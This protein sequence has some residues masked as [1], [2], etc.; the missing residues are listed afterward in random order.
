MTRA[1]L[2]RIVVLCT[3]ALAADAA[4]TEAQISERVAD[5]AL[6]EAA[7]AA[8][9]GP[10]GRGMAANL[11]GFDTPLPDFTDCSFV[12]VEPDADWMAVAHDGGPVRA[13]D[14]MMPAFGE[15]MT[16]AELQQTLDY[17]RGFCTNTAWPR[18]ELNFP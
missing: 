9:H 12:T 11:I 13:F 7:C 6:Y 15:A 16:D 4:K 10:D 8:C 14:R 1:L 18:G 3:A 17:I 5:R 2:P